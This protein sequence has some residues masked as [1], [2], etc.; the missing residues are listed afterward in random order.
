MIPEFTGNNQCVVSGKIDSA[1]SR[2]SRNPYFLLPIPMPS[3]KTNAMGDGPWPIG[4]VSAG[5]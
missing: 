4:P 1:L 5:V 2:K 3:G